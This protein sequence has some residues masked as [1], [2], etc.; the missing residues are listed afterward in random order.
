MTVYD[1]DR[2]ERLTDITRLISEYADAEEKCAVYMAQHP[3]AADP[4]DEDLWA[5]DDAGVAVA[6]ALIDLIDDGYAI[7][8][9]DES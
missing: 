8:K 5:R 9:E 2:D 1:P 6:H 7:T 3:A 4:P